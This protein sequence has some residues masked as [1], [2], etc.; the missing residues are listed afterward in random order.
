MYSTHHASDTGNCRF[1]SVPKREPY[2]CV[3]MYS[4]NGVIRSRVVSCDEQNAF[5]CQYGTVVIYWS[6]PLP[7]QEEKV[8]Y[9]DS[10][11]T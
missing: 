4:Y 5:I 3:G 11:V 1:I 10:G 7:Q 6:V 2:Q 8:I 9:N